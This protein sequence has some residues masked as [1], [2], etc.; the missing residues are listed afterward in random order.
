MN[1]K[2]DYD[3]PIVPSKSYDPKWLVNKQ[4]LPSIYI[5]S[6]KRFMDLSSLG[7]LIAR[8][9]F[10]TTIAIN[11]RGVEMVYIPGSE[12]YRFLHEYE[13]GLITTLKK[14]TLQRPLVLRAYRRFMKN[15]KKRAKI[16][17]SI[18]GTSTTA[19]RSR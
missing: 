11:D 13:L 9:Y 4:I 19:K 8:G 2:I 18:V 6:K 17:L 14:K 5:N 16:P 1:T 15:Y 10:Q 7:G 3:V 12:V